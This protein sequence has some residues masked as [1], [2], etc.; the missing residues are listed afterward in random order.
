MR[1]DWNIFVAAL[2]SDYDQINSGLVMPYVVKALVGDS[3]I[4]AFFVPLFMALTSTVSSSMIAVSGILSFDL[5]KTYINPKVSDQKLVKICYLAVVAHG[6][7]IFAIS[8]ALNY[9]G[10]D[11]TWIGYFCPIHSCPKIIPLDFNLTWSG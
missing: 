3:E 7:F 8:L 5:Y 2:E 10:A 4:V 6:C 1:M 9:G 11:M